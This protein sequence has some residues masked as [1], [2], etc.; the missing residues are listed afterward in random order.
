MPVVGMNRLH[1]YILII[2]SVDIVLEVIQSVLLHINKV[3][4]YALNYLM[5]Y[6][7]I[8]CSLFYVIINISYSVF[9]M[10]NISYSVESRY[11]VCEQFCYAYPTKMAGIM[12]F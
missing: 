1:R 12:I 4:F 8:L 6:A 9:L 7:A 11:S 5:P 2:V 10:S 3:C